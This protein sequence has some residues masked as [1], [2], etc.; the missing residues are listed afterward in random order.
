M[1]TLRPV[2][3]G[4]RTDHPIEGLPFV[5]DSLLDL[6]DPAAIEAIG[7]KVSDDMWGRFDHNRRSGGWMAFTTHPVRRDLAWSVRHHPEHGTSVLLMRDAD[8]SPMHMQWWSKALLWRSGGYW[9]DG[10]TWYRPAQIWDAASEEYVRRPVTAATT[11]TASDVLDRFSTVKEARVLDVTEVDTDAAAPE[12]WDDHLIL[13]SQHRSEGARP[14]TQCVVS[15]TAPELTGDRLIG[16]P[17]MAKLGGIS[18]STLRAYLA[19]GEGGVPQPQASRSGRNLWARPVGEDWAEARRRSP[20]SAAEALAANEHSALP[21]GLSDLRQRF[22]GLFR[23]TLWDRPERRKRWALRYRTADQVTQV[24]SELG[25]VVADSID[26][27]L[28]TDALA[29]TIRHA[30]LDEIATGIDLDGDEEDPVFFGITQD[31]A[32]M[33]DWLIRHHP[34]RAQHV[35]GETIG[36]A[37]RRWEKV[38]RSA[39]AQSLRTA[40]ALDGQ[41]D[42]DVYRDYLDRV[43]PPEE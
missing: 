40:L 7:R 15:L 34:D 3:N 42:E 20:G 12:R 10:A 5:D 30:L 9:W 24:A 17:E 8:A 29:T 28:P 32:K 26:D 36:D 43:L 2:A 1:Q 39:L 23:M 22:T 41:L 38:P 18:A 35:I 27:I 25:L 11:L 19:R 21:S 16:V 13:W 4:L 31:V 37:E 33:L 14:L 6:D